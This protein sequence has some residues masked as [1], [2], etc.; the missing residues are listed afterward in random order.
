M[1]CFWHT[2]GSGAQRALISRWDNWRK[3]RKKENVKTGQELPCIAPVLHCENR[4][5]E[6]KKHL[7]GNCFCLSPN[8]G[9]GGKRE[10]KNC[11]H[12]SCFI[13]HLDG[14]TGE[15]WEDEFSLMIS[16]WFT[17]CPSVF[18]I[19]ARRDRLERCRPLPFPELLVIWSS[20]ERNGTILEH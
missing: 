4:L 19:L 2:D 17:C 13:S 5:G 8:A 14:L 20:E 16:C 9:T 12:T 15:I 6:Q 18:V 3:T 11:Q 7:S 10:A 1:N